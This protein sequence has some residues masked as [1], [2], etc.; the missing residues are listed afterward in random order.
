M[1][2]GF[3]A[4]T[5]VTTIYYFH[6]LFP[7][8]LVGQVHPLYSF[9]IQKQILL[10]HRPGLQVYLHCPCICDSPHLDIDKQNDKLVR[11]TKV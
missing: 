4:P 8:F 3:S 6:F 11:K 2:T 7:C 10:C 9:D 1:Y 5:S